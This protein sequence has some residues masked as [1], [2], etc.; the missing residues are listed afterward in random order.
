MKR[1]RLKNLYLNNKTDTSRTAYIKQCDQKDHCASLDEKGA[2]GKQFWRTVKQLLSDKVKQSE[3][4][5][6]VEVEEIIIEDRK[7]FKKNVFKCGKKLKIQEY[8]EAD[9]FANNI[10]HS[11]LKTVMDLRNNLSISAIN[12]SNHDSIIH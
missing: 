3:K 5:T 8:Q 1:T 4:I 10:S 6:L 7:N 12:N 11:M 9:P 2:V